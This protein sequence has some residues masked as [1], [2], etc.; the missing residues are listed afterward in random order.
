MPPYRRMTESTSRLPHSR[1][2][3]RSIAPVLLVFT[4]IALLPRLA[5]ISRSVSHKRYD[6]TDRWCGENDVAT[7]L[8]GLRFVIGPP[9][10]SELE[11]D[12]SESRKRQLLPDVAY[13]F[14]VE[15]TAVRKAVA[16]L[17]A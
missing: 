11:L 2:K 15:P 3:I 6:C 8:R 10:R 7:V 13:P 9:C 1:L 4:Q 16:R 14:V 12:R 5:P 17:T